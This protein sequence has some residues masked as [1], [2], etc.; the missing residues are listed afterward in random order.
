[1]PGIR[2]VQLV[3]RLYLRKF[4]LIVYRTRE[5][6]R[7]MCTV[8]NIKKTHSWVTKIDKRGTEIEYDQ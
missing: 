3:G 1:M 6:L 5:D 8:L 4:N 7:E 2:N